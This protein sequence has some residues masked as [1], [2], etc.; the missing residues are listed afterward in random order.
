MLPS[1]VMSNKTVVTAI[2]T[3][4]HTRDAPYLNFHNIFKWAGGRF[5]WELPCLCYPNK[6]LS[7][8]TWKSILMW[9]TCHFN[10]EFLWLFFFFLYRI[11]KV[12][13]EVIFGWHDDKTHLHFLSWV[14]ETHVYCVRANPGK[15]ISFSVTQRGALR[16]GEIYCDA[17]KV[18]FPHPPP[19]TTLQVSTECK[20]IP[21][22]VLW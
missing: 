19:D 4:I 16:Y 2:L 21:L 6:H 5:C 12:K 9:V 14:K 7:C 17:A 1:H 22:C 20:W 18:V 3:E 10:W 15:G 13:P 11:F 8:S